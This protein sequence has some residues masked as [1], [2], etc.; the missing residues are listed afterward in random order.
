VI[1]IAP[2]GAALC[3]RIEGLGAPRQPDGTVPRDVKGVPK[4]GL[5]I[6]H[7]VV[8]SGDE[9]SG[10]ITNPDDGTDWH[11]TL[12]VDD[13]GRL[14]LRGYVLVPLFGQTQ[15][16]PRFLGELGTDCA[17]MPRERGTPAQPFR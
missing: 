5:T 3:G 17:I 4:C 6:L 12:S 9:W 1:E 8:P 15:I 10:I 13:Q 16:W 2:C 14:H 7:D 11:C